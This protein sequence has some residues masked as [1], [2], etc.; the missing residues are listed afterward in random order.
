MDASS[1]IP[2]LALKLKPDLSVV[3][4]CC[5]PGAKLLYLNDL[6]NENSTITGVDISQDRLRV[7]KSL[8]KKYKARENI[9]L[10]CGNALNFQSEQRF[11]RVLVDAE[12]THE[13]SIK[14]MNK[15]TTQ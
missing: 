7:T 11:D 3:D 13:G 12:C 9:N 14:H 8:L 2:V 15:F 1:A 4:I 5:A 10:I 6:L